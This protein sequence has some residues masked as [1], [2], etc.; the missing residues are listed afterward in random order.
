MSEFYSGV[1]SILKKV[2]NTSDESFSDRNV[3]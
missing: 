3:L 2:L 1:G